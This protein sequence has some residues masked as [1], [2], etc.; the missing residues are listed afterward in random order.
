M[1]KCPGRRV[2]KSTEARPRKNTDPRASGQD[3]GNAAPALTPHAPP[4]PP[5]SWVCPQTADETAPQK[6]DYSVRTGDVGPC[7][8]LLGR[9]LD[10]DFHDDVCDARSSEGRSSD[11]HSRAVSVVPQ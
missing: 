3:T 8:L 6:P 4:A 5:T 7:L 9:M 2:R 10:L 1:R 11:P